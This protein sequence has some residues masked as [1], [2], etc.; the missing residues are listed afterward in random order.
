MQLKELVS[1]QAVS[2]VWLTMFQDV[3]HLVSSVIGI[4]AVNSPNDLQKP[5]AHVTGDCLFLFWIGKGGEKA[6]APNCA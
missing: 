5:P 4:D 1:G 3:K 2:K 6:A